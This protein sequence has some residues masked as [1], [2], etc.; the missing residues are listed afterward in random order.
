MD[1]SALTPY[2]TN[3]LPQDTDTILTFVNP[4]SELCWNTRQ[5]ELR[6]LL[7]V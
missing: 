5:L 1:C 6:L 7:A 4:G 3:H 2:N